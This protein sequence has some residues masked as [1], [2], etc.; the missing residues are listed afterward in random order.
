LKK[1]ILLVEP[2]FPIPPKSKN[3]KDFLPIGL[4][5]IASYLKSNGYDVQLVRGEL[6]LEEFSFEPDEIW[7]TSLFT[8]WS[9]YVKNSVQ[10]Y[11]K[12]FPKAKVIVGGIY[13]SLMPEHCK[14]YTGCDE[15]FTGVYEEAEDFLP[16]YELLNAKNPHP[17]D[18][19]IVH[20]SRGCLR[21]CK[22]CG[23]WK[24]EPKFRGVESIKDKIKYRKVVFYDNNFLANPHIEEILREIIDLKR[25]KKLLWCES[26][27]GFDGR[28]LLEKPH[29]GK[30][31]KRAGFRYPRIAWDWE[32]NMHKEIKNQ[33]DVLID[34]GYKSKDV[35]VFVLYNWDIPFREMERKRVKCWEWQVQIADCRYRP[36]NQTFDNYNPR[37]IGQ[38]NE[39]YY[40]HEEAGWTDALVKQF[41]KNVRRQNICVRHGY[42]F[43]CKEFEQKGVANEIM[44]ATKF[45]KTKEEKI[46]FLEENKISYWFPD[47]ITTP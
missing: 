43:Y 25:R 16:D 44:R 39:D 8:Y 20:T 7:I 45:M 9:K 26:Q 17:I 28:I 24:I 4:L 35:Y 38:T 13:A 1:K 11:K 31:I 12:I 41:R 5:K 23:T 27:S 46:K 10:Y 15:V 36:L 40:I 29:L 2:Q 21:R 42:P 47:E 22:F 37:K 3:H 14:E 33:I 19:Q 18:Y 30:M 6:K 34:A 32:Y